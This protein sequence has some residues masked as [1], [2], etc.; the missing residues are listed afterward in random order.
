MQ[1]HY[2]I[3]T[4]TA[5]IERLTVL[6]VGKDVE[7]VEH[8]LWECTTAQPLWKMAWKFLRKLNI[9]DGYRVSV[10]REENSSRGQKVVMAANNMNVL[11]AFKLNT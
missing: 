10:L 1:G 6:S 8:C 5:K 11:N 2:H 3:P 9:H 4:R 7:E